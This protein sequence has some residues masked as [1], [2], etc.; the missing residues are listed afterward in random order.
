M[1][2]KDLEKIATSCESP[3]R[4]KRFLIGAYLSHHEFIAS[5]IHN[6]TMDKDLYKDWN[7]TGYVRDWQ[8]A[9]EY[10]CW[11]RSADKKARNGKQSTR[12]AQ[13]QKL[14]EEWEG[15]P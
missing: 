13:F 2:S 11:R 7:R 12:Y 14:A 3:Y 6:R 1:K 8:R 10:V 9:K 5:A 4:E 15:K